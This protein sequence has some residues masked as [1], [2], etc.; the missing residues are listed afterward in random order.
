[1]A[2]LPN[3]LGSVG[4]ASPGRINEYPCPLEVLKA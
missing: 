4:L 3:S 1:L 2:H